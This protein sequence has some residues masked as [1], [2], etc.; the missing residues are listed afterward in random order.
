MLVKK[1]WPPST[2]N[3]PLDNRTVCGVGASPSHILNRFGHQQSDRIASQSTRSSGPGT[4]PGKRVIHCQSRTRRGGDNCFGISYSHTS[5]LRFLL[6]L[7]NQRTCASFPFLFHSPASPR[8][9]RPLPYSLLFNF[10]FLGQVYIY[11]ER[12]G[13][14]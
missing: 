1:V 2:V 12:G 10:I 8:S 9:P 4:G 11:A 14:E 3:T 13:I 7:I 5:S 6:L